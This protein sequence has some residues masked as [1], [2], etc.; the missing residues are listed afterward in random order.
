MARWRF[1]DFEGYHNFTW[2]TLAP[3]GAKE[4]TL[5]EPPPSFSTRLRTVGYERICTTRPTAHIAWPWQMKEQRKQLS[6]Q[7]V[8]AWQCC[9]EPQSA[10]QSAL[11][12]P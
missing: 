5:L 1:D 7:F 8:A 4:R 2:A 11:G 9:D 6:R 10:E 3:H 12:K